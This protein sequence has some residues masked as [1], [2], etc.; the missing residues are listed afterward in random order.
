MK[1]QYIGGLFKGTLGILEIPDDNQMGIYSRSVYNNTPYNK[2]KEV[3]SEGAA[4]NPVPQKV[5]DPSPIKHIFYI[6]K[7]N[8]T[9]DQV[10]GDI[11]EGN[12]DP[13]LVLFGEKITPNQHAIAREFVLLDNFYVNGEVSADG[14]NW[15]MG[16]YATDYLEKNWPTSYGGRG[17]IYPGEGAR[18]K[19]QITGT[20]FYGISANGK[21]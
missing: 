8:R 9:Y 13:S 17:G 19:S 10:L 15:T 11:P 7:E 3:S 1:V 20:A 14:H 12:G 6:I 16:A 2:N 18:A 5:G 21:A 4:G